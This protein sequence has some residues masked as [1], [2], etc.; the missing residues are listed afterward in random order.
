MIN[1]SK[2]EIALIVIMIG[3]AM[4][5]LYDYWPD[6]EALHRD[7]VIREFESGQKYKQV[8]ENIVKRYLSSN[9]F[10]HDSKIINDRIV[11]AYNEQTKVIKSRVK[12]LEFYYATTKQNLFN[13]T[14]GKSAINKMEREDELI[15]K[16]TVLYDGKKIALMKSGNIYLRLGEANVSHED[17][18]VIEERKVTIDN[19]E[20]SEKR[21]FRIFM[22]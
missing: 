17:N 4:V 5:T 19:R 2:S 10:V 20:K 1:F 6:D 13:K 14:R 16:G 21:T 11:S 15:L 22:R 9:E 18:V 7:D 12:E 3:V 8:A